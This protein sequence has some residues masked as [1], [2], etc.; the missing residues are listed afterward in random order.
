MTALFSPSPAAALLAPGAGSGRDHSCLTAIEAA[1]APLPVERMDFPYRRRGGTAPDRAPVLL[2]AVVQTASALA[3]AHALD[4]AGLVLGGRSM[5][6][7]MCSMAV[8]EG[9]PAAG[10][11][12]VSYPLHPPGR[13]DRLR[14]AHLPD[15]AVPCLFVSGTRDA[16]A[17]PAELEAATAAIPAPVEHVWVEGG[18]HD[19][20]GA[21]Q[22]VA[23][24]V[25]AWVR[26]LGPP[27]RRP[28]G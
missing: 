9:L 22:K 7:R 13:P 5:G 19:L 2:A 26:A 12:L 17:T 23:T 10:L 25:A 11:V 1:L 24:A 18:R 6:G 14:T 27:V 3:T 20:K 28:A 16:F 21:D 8:A 15:I 4:P